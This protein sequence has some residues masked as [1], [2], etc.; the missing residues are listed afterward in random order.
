MIKILL[1][2]DH[3]IVRDGLKQIISNQS[4]MV[5]CD[6]ASTGQEV[7]DLI[8]KNDYNLVLLD[9][10]M[11]GRN[12]LEIIKEIKA[13]NPDTKILVLSMYPEEQ[14]AVRVLKTGGSGYLTKETAS[15]ELINAIR[16]VSQ[17]GKYVSQDI[18]EKLVF[19]FDKDLSK[20]IHEKLSNREFQ[21]MCL[22]ASG[23]TVKEIANELSLSI[24]TISTYRSRILEKAH[25]KTNSEL[26]YYALKQNLIE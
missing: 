8:Y 16:K 24:K 13:E 9:I 4:D 21:I 22:I 3:K 17:G 19:E 7:L 26:T 14:Y 1:A 20:P 10:S 6:E 12:G 25:M 18:T 23:K 11:P 5:V 2:D 15:E